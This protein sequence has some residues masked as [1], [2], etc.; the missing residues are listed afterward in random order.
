[1]PIAGGQRLTVAPWGSLTLTGTSLLLVVPL[2]SCPNAPLP[3]ART[4]RL[5]VPAATAPAAAAPPA[6]TRP[7]FI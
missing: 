2:P 7:I 6:L 3:H 4:D 5:A 1:V